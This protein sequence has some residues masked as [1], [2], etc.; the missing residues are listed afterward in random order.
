MNHPGGFRISHSK[1]VD[2]HPWAALFGNSFL[3]QELVHMCL[4]AY[5]VF[6]L[7]VA[8]WYALCF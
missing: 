7:L 4:A 8:R 3:W 2:V 1:A 6:G 5:I